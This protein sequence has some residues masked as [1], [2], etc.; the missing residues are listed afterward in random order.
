MRMVTPGSAPMTYPYKTVHGEEILADVYCPLSG[1]APRATLVYIHGGCLMYG[2]RQQIHP[3]QLETYRR[4]G[5]TV[6]SLDYRLAP[7]TKLPEIIADLRDAFRWVAEAGPQHFD[8]DPERIAVVGHSAGAYLTLMAGTCA[9]P[10]PCA[11]ISFYGYGDIVSD[12]YG[13]PDPF[14]CQQPH[15]SAE[16]AM[17]NRGQLYL[18]C[19]QNG[20]WPQEVG[21][22]DP[23]IEPEFFL[24]YCPS[25]N[26]AADYPPTLLLHGDLDTDVP[27]AQSVQ[28]AEALAQQRVP[29]ELMTLAGY[30]H[31]FDAKMDDP[32]V[33]KAIQQVLA[34]LN[35]H[36]P[37]GR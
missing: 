8:V 27:Y 19:R 10:R 23:A 35:S 6:V 26:V 20:L 34:F 9:I 37:S 11:L 32:V 33:Q 3:E 12:W 5:Y 15:V 24:P 7:E 30:G 25:H 29:H 1:S 2:S 36:T 21:G 16:E 4:A 28:M 17:R 14:Y 13:K 18:Y 22:R 31:G